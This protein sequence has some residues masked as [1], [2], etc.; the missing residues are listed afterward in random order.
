MQM[1]KFVFASFIQKVIF[2]LMKQSI[3]RLNLVTA[4]NLEEFNMCIKC[5]QS[6]SKAYLLFTLDMY[7]ELIALACLYTLPVR[8]YGAIYG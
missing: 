4:I 2:M 7:R 8:W 1:L 6:D 3:G 5:N